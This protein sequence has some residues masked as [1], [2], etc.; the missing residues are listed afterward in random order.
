MNCY[1]DDCYSVIFT[2]GNK[3]WKHIEKNI[4]NMNNYYINNQ[5]KMNMK[6]NNGDDFYKQCLRKGK[7]Y[8]NRRIYNKTHEE[9]KNPWNYNE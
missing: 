2:Q 1:V 3:I 6:K 9:D 4:L 8:Y 5:L 7:T